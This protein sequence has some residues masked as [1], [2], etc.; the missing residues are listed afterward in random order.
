MNR[1]A[2]QLSPSPSRWKTTGCSTAERPEGTHVH[3]HGGSWID[4]P[5]SYHNGAAGFSF[6]DGHAEVHKWKA[7]LSTARANKIKFNNSIDAPSKAG[8]ADIHWM[9]Y[10]GGRNSEKSF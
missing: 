10:R 9:S 1:P 3:P 4:Q 6:A 5:A 8:D 7:S 2:E